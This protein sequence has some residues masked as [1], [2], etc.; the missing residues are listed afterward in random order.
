MSIPLQKEEVKI[1]KNIKFIENFYFSQIEVR[2][3]QASNS[4]IIR[5]PAI[6]LYFDSFSINLEVNLKKLI[7][8]STCSKP[9]IQNL[10]IIQMADIA[11][12]E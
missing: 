12:F 3:K 4:M 2:L 9:T 1:K 8:K 5:Q 10:R 6:S 11:P 7:Q